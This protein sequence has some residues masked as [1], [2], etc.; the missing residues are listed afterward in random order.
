[1]YINVLLIRSNLLGSW[2]IPTELGKV[3]GEFPVP[4][5]GDQPSATADGSDLLCHDL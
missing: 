2:K 5:C 4:A 3:R 1:M